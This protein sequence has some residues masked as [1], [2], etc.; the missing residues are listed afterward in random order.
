VTNDD[1]QGWAS[2]PGGPPR[3]DGSTIAAGPAG[4]IWEASRQAVARLQARRAI[5]AE[6]DTWHR[7][8]VL[9]SAAALLTRQ[10]W[11]WLAAK[12]MAL[13]TACWLATYLRARRA[14][15]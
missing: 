3:G 4:T 14:T 13:L 9:T 15:A 12:A 11:L 2:G 10:L 6:A 7:A 8:S 1:S 5:L